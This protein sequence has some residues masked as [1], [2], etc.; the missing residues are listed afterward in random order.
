M[1]MGY[2][3][4]FL[5]TLRYINFVDVTFHED[6]PYFSPCIAP[7]WDSTS[8]PKGFL[9]FLHHLYLLPQGFLQSLHLLRCH[10]LFLTQR[11]IWIYQCP[12]LL[13]LDSLPSMFFIHPS[14]FLVISSLILDSL[15]HCRTPLH[16]V[17]HLLMIS[18]FPL[19]CRRVHIC[20]Q[21]S[22]CPFCMVWL[23][24]SHLPYLFPCCVLQ[25][26]AQYI[27]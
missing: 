8:P 13:I 24:F 4:Y 7:P 20:V 26:A 1:Q 22:R 19:P 17:A 21:A 18:T 14:T 16:L 25:V 27:S 6:V 9:L 15:Y 23:P 2:F 11:T 5:D 10:L 12:W 3:F